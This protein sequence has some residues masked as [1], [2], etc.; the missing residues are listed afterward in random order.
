MDG[1]RTMHQTERRLSELGAEIVKSC[2]LPAH[3]IAV[4]C[5]GWQMGKVVMTT[6]QSFTNQQLNTIVPNNHVNHMFLYYALSTRRNELKNLGSAGTRTPILNK[7]RFEDVKVRVPPRP[8]QNRIASVLSAYDD[9]IENNT[10]RIEILEDLARSLYREWFV[11]YRFPGRGNLPLVES[12][13]GTVPDGWTVALIPEVF[14]IVGGGT[15]SKEVVDY[16]LGGDIEWYTPTDLTGASSMFMDASKARITRAG[17]EQSS[18]RLFPP[19]SVMLTSRATIG[20]ISINTTWASTNQ[21]FITCLPNRKFPLYVM[22]HWLKENVPLFV[23]LGTGSTFKEITKSTFKKIE[24]A[25]PPEPLAHK[26][27]AHASPIGAQVLN[28]ERRNRLLR[29]TRDLLLP[30]LISGEIDV[31]SLPDPTA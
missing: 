11:H 27:E 30:R 25:I 19:M 9:L 12:T 21:G 1:R 23:S 14:E 24:L 28:L 6:C 8:V 13:I 20:A 7:S 10:R 31:S 15:P 22:Y 26:F 5:I 29:T 16:W 17:L 3:S 18:A 4:S 2:R